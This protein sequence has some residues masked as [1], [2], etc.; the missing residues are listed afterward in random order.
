MKE[1]VGYRENKRMDVREEC[2]SWASWAMASTAALA[3]RAR[4]HSLQRLAAEGGFEG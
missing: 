3:R 2:E 4:V 1:R